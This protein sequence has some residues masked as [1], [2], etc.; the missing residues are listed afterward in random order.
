MPDRKPFVYS[1]GWRL[2][3]AEPGHGCNL[4]RDQQSGTG[5]DQAAP[6][7]SL[8]ALRVKVAFPDNL[9]KRLIRER[10]HCRRLLMHRKS[11]MP[12][13]RIHCLRTY[14]SRFRKEAGLV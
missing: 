2:G 9:R 8:I 3:R 4:A 7:A 11:P 12:S 13:D 6:L 1:G 14:L 10:S 5:A